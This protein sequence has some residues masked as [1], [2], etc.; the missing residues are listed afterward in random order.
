METAA[1]QWTNSG[2]CISQ[3][4]IPEVIAAARRFQL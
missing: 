3:N 1:G 2:P 4:V